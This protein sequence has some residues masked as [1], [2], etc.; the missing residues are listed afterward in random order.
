MIKWTYIPFLRPETENMT[1]TCQP[2]VNQLGKHSSKNNTK[3]FSSL[4]YF[5][6]TVRRQDSTTENV[7]LMDELVRFLDAVEPDALN[8]QLRYPKSFQYNEDSLYH[9]HGFPEEAR[10]RFARSN[11]KID[12]EVGVREQW[13]RRALGDSSE[14]KTVLALEKLFQ[15]RTSLLLTVVKAEK[16]L[17]LGRQSAKHSLIKARKQD[18][19]MFSLP[20]TV[21]ERL[22][23]EALGYDLL[24]LE[25]EISYLIALT[26]QTP[27]ISRKDLLAAVKAKK[28]RPGFQL[29]DDGEKCQYIRTMTREVH[30]MF[31]KSRRGHLSSDEVANHLTRFLLDLEKKDE[32]DLL[33]ADKASSTFF[34]VEVKSFPQDGIYNE[35]G[36]KRALKKANE[37]MGK[38]NK[39]FQNALAPACQLSPSWTKIN[40][41]C[42]PEM[43]SRKQFRD[44]GISEHKL[45][46][47]LT[48]E[49]LASGHWFE[50]LKL[51]DR[52]ANDKDYKR[53]LAV[54]FSSQYVSFDCQLLDHM[55]E[56]MVTHTKLVGKRK[57]SEVVG[58]GG[59]EGPVDGAKAIKLSD[60]KGKPLGH[61]WSILFWT[62]Q[63]LNILEQSKQGKN[64]VVCG[65]YGTGKTSLLV[66]GALEAAK[67]L[68]SK[69]FFIPAANSPK[70]SDGNDQLILDEAVR[71]K[72]DGTRVEVVTMG[73]LRKLFKANASDGDER[74]QLIKEF[75]K[76]QEQST[77]VFIDE[78][79]ISQKDLKSLID[80]KDTDLEKT[81]KVLELHSQQTWLAL[82][83]LSL[84]DNSEKPLL[85]ETKTTMFN[86]LQSIAW[87]QHPYTILKA[88]F[89]KSDSLKDLL[90]TTS[91]TSFKFHQLDLRVRNSSS[92]GSSAPDDIS[93]LSLR[94]F[95]FQ[96][97]VIK[98]ASNASTIVG[99]KPSFVNM[100][101]TSYD[102]Y[103]L[104]MQETLSKILKLKHQPTEQAV[105]L[106]GE[107]I[108]VTK[109]SEA[110]NK[111]K[112]NPLTFPPTPTE[113]QKQ[114]LH[115]WLQGNVGGLLVISN[116]QFSGMEAST[117]VFVTNN[118]VEEIGARSGLLR[119][120]TRL[121]VVSFTKEV[122]LEE[123]EKHFV[124]HDMTKTKE[125]RMDKGKKRK[126]EEEEEAKKGEAFGEQVDK[127][128]VTI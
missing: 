125:E 110:V 3:S 82:S 102:D 92:I 52:M 112:F 101:G 35:E 122:D 16:I 23:A 51:P 48:A 39:F 76:A 117:C 58:V 45:K 119:A 40:L 17:T 75:I 73:D 26:P 60:L 93:K 109:V 78:L 61:V 94:G 87:S 83:A 70:S 107:G 2:L 14:A 43:S 106:C 96:T 127:N 22:L 18:P 32:F 31:N 21:E 9:I 65:D 114:N 57:L 41:V 13:R 55:E 25:S 80:G 71:M 64:L 121:V 108:S 54:C 19:K 111:L 98:G 105:I 37:N 46:F 33:L 15:R 67:D 69:V 79:P 99:M 124:V 6:V 53:L 90:T 118:I 91:T 85:P 97:C 5:P 7:M 120:N 11:Q 68:N 126:R 27:S 29:M 113:D 50:A 100:P 77:R 84:L 89:S 28:V 95:S 104:A 128:D 59:E 115:S 47:I 103:T 88:G 66:F 38:G 12:K 10:T 56:E 63:Q 36:L 1:W 49:E 86:S 72:F 4:D 8:K 20:L 123:V 24:Q 30:Q 81:L 62:R 34:Q 116:L 42:F 44:L 74:H